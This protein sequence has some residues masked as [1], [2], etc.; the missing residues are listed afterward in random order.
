MFTQLKRI[1]Y[2]VFSAPQA[3]AEDT[4]LLAPPAAP[5]A[6]GPLPPLAAVDHQVTLIA[7]EMAP[8][9]VRFYD[10]GQQQQ[11]YQQA[12][13]DLLGVGPAAAAV[14]HRTKL[15][16]EEG[17]VDPAPVPAAGEGTARARSLAKLKVNRTV[18][19]NVLPQ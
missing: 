15:I 18:A 4:S 3:S 14:D 17:P 16:G 8:R 1:I 2:F 7:P 12:M 19:F 10:N 13:E 11:T 5:A 6:P 9:E